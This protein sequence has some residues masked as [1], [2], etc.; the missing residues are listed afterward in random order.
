MKDKP[1]QRKGVKSNTHV[2]KKFEKAAKDFF[3]SKGLHLQKNISID[4]GING[5]KSHNFDLGNLNE[6]ILVECKSHTDRR[7]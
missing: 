6:K 3:T 7:R 5:K 4:I 1:F 2:G